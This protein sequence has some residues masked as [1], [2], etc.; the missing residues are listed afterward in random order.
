MMTADA[1]PTYFKTLFGKHDNR[2]KDLRYTINLYSFNLP[3]PHTWGGDET[4]HIAPIVAIARQYGCDV[5]VI[6][7]DQA[8]FDVADSYYQS[9]PPKSRHGQE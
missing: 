2:F 8:G 1:L 6:H 4:A 5:Y 3:P 7:P 9:F